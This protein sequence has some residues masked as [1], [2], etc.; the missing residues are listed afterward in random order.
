MLLPVNFIITRSPGPVI[1]GHLDFQLLPALY[2]P[3]LPDPPHPCP[4]A[5]P[6]PAPPPACSVPLSEHLRIAGEHPITWLSGFT[7]NSWPQTSKDMQHCQNSC[8]NALGSAISHSLR[9]AFLTLSFLPNHF[10]GCALTPCMIL[11][12]Y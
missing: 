11:A 4:P 7:S 6:P 1:P 3:I 10:S 5:V 9:G 2:I 12:S 8:R